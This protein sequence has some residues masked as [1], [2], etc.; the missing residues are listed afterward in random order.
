MFFQESRTW[1]SKT[2]G[3]IKICWWHN[4]PTTVINGKYQHFLDAVQTKSSRNCL[5]CTAYQSSWLSSQSHEARFSE[6]LTRLIS[7]IMDYILLHKYVTFT[8]PRQRENG[9]CLGGSWHVKTKGTFNK[10]CPNFP[11]A[12]QRNLWFLH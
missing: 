8:S 1:C 3:T 4:S 5:K 2:S 11:A 12:P 10:D 9:K 7:G 6:N